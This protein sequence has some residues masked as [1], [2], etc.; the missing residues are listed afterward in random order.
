MYVYVYYICTLTAFAGGGPAGGGTSVVAV[1]VFDKSMDGSDDL[2]ESLLAAGE[3]KPIVL[4][5]YQIHN[6]I[7]N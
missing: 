4:I 3:T 6:Y 2:L 7:Y 1:L 5:A